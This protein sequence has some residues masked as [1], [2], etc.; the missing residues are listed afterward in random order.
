MQRDLRIDAIRGGGI[1]MIA[2]DHFSGLAQAIAVQPF[3]MPFPTWTRIGWS[4][5]AEFFVF[6]SGYILALVYSRTLERQGPLLL[7]ARAV[8]RAWQIY[9]ANLLTLCA[10]L[11]ALSTPA[12]SSESLEMS[13][14]IAALFGTQASWHETNRLISFLSLR[15]APA[16]FE[17]LH[18][19]VVLLL[20]APLLLIAARLSRLAVLG[21]SLAMWLC[22][23]V[24]PGLNI[25]DWHFNPFAW[26][27]MFVLGML[28]SVTRVFERIDALRGRRVL[29]TGSAAVLGFAALL[30]TIDKAGWA[31]PLIG[32]IDIPGIDK[33]VLGPLRV[34]HFIASVILITQ[35][36]PDSPRLAS[37]RLAGIVARI[38]QHSLECFC[39][40]TLLAYIGAAALARMQPFGSGSVFVTG[41]VIVLLLCASAPFLLWFRSEPWRANRRPAPASAIDSPS[42]SIHARQ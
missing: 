24:D 32:A 33:P 15:D 17:I 4:S 23:Q 5:A 13:T 42:R 34:V 22:V 30:K 19:Y 20:V 14:G 27:L 2:V 6:F 21:G 39:F 37:S 38:G 41:C 35:I 31:L 16:F 26:Q 9:V 8:H 25:P 3:V 1:L 7:Q 12:L 10:V 18:L 40:S 29:L 28:C 36:V 11:L